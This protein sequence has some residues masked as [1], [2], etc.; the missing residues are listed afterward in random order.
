MNAPWLHLRRLG[1][2]AALLMLTACDAWSQLAE[3]PAVRVPA[4]VQ[5]PALRSSPG[6][7][8]LTLAGGCFWGVQGV[9]Q[10][11]RGV[12]QAVSGYAGGDK[13][14]ASYRVVGSGLTGHA[15]S[16]EITYDP[17]EVTLTDLLR[18][19]FSVAH[20]PTE[21]NRQGPDEGTQYR[22]AVFYRDETQR[23]LTAA[24]IAQLDK[25]HVFPAAIATQ[26]TPFKGFFPAEGYHQDYL[27]LHPESS[28]ISHF[29]LPKLKSLKALFPELYRESPVLV[30]SR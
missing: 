16:V 8:T 7:E 26:L 21:H 3:A 2:L 13:A 5:A 12:R 15:E 24:Y 14:T 11:V 18:V 17:S 27:T 10:H 6:T 22:S 4:A 23:Q 30:G 1:G 29:D 20:N 19:Y 9:F 25:A 28:Y